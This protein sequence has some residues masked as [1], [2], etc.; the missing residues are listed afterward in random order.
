MKTEKWLRRKVEAANILDAAKTLPIRH[1][2]I[3]RF[4]DEAWVPAET[5]LTW[6]KAGLQQGDDAGLDAAVSYAKRAVCRRIDT[7]ILYYHLRGYAN[8]NYPPKIEALRDIG[9]SIPDIVSRWIINPRND[10]E[11]SYQ[12]AT[13]NMAR[14]ATEIADLFL[15]ATREEAALGAVIGLGWTVQSSCSE[16]PEGVTVE[17]RDLGTAPMLFLDIFE[18]PEAAKIIFPTDKDILVAPL[19]DFPDKEAIELGKLLRQHHVLPGRSATSFPA[20]YYEEIKRQ[21][22][23]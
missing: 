23:L 8:R 22:D 1:A 7:L 2:Y 18:Q 11:H 17:L 5:Y 16:G 15:P 20:I 4:P 13:P 19:K 12:R 14:D 21:A 6:A 9:I 10:L 3:S